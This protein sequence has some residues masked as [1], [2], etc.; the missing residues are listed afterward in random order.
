M[1]THFDRFAVVDNTL[2][3]RVTGW[4][5]WFASRDDAEQAKREAEVRMVVCEV[6]LGRL[7]NAWSKRC[8]NM[9]RGNVTVSSVVERANT[10]LMA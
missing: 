7:R 2:F 1:D 9:V 6:E 5:I 3:D 10:E 4:M 8:V